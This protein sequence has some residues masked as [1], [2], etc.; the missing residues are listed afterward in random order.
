MAAPGEGTVDEWPAGERYVLRGEQVRK[1][2]A[3]EHRFR[4]PE[5][6]AS[7]RLVLVGGPLAPIGA[8]ENTLNALM[9]RAAFVLTQG[10]SSVRLRQGDQRRWLPERHHRP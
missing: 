7:A 5:H 1:P 2:P 6:V 3:T 10:T 9:P 4:K 8:Q